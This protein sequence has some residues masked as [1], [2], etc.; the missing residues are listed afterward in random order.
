MTGRQEALALV[1]VLEE[2]E[3]RLTLGRF[4]H[5]DAWRLG[6]L[7][8]ELSLERQAPVAITILRGPQRLFHCALPGSSTDNDEWLARKCRVVE[9]YAESS[10]L[11]GTRF[12]AKGTTFEESSRLA[13][14]RYAAHGGAFPLRVDGVGVIGAA[15]VSGLRQAED[16]AL[17][18]TALER[19]I[20]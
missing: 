7:L 11:V 16:H 15:A 12:R 13:P 8:R 9:R 18:V 1:P 19:L 4:T 14:D 17:V 3:H 2:Q 20:A 6:G 5:E 10:Y